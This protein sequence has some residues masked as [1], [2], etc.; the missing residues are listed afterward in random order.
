MDERLLSP[1]IGRYFNKC[2]TKPVKAKTGVFKEKTYKIN[3]QYN[4]I[5]AKQEFKNP[6]FDLNK[7][8]QEAVETIQQTLEQ[9]KRTFKTFLLHG[10]TGSG[11]TEVYLHVIDHVIKSGA[12]IV[13]VPEI[14]LTPQTLMRFQERFPETIAV[15]HS[16]R[17]HKQRLDSW[18]DALRGEA[19]IVIGTRSAIFTPLKNPGIIILDEEHDLS[20]KQQAGLRY[21]ARD[22]A[23][24]RGKLENVPVV[25]G[26]ATPSLES[27][28]NAARGRY[29]LLSLPNRAGV[30]VQSPFH[31][32]DLRTQKIVDGLAAGMITA[33][34][35]HLMNNGQVLVFVNRR[36]Y[37]PVSMCP[38]CNAIVRL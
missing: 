20:F 31:I 17:T 14:N 27:I 8:Q 4:Q 16:R 36:G 33:I 23:V 10:V 1:R 3:I 18:L 2:I 7:E 15:I 6:N 9:K 37:A 30:A 28:N 12:G 5:L 25:L 35:K 21:S 24:I 26:S 34:E 13:L 32:I 38:S 22:L 11:K 29:K 19:A